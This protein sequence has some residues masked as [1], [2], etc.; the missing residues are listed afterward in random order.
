M[1]STAVRRE[2]PPRSRPQA[3]LRKTF[4]STRGQRCLRNAALPH[5]DT[6][7]MRRCRKA[8]RQKYRTFVMPHR[9]NPVSMHCRI[10]SLVKGVNDEMPN[11]GN[12]AFPQRRMAG[13][14]HRCIAAMP[15]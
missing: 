1:K 12:T 5:F 14:L 15:T 7:E 6:D 13:M 10:S 4:G 2:A 3:R 11:D 8:E 9:G